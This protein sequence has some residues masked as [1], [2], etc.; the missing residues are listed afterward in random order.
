MRNDL[1][2]RVGE[3]EG[4]KSFAVD[5]ADVGQSYHIEWLPPQTIPAPHKIPAITEGECIIAVCSICI[6]KD[7]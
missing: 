2:E 1:S 5:G 7:A 6:L 4:S 3:N